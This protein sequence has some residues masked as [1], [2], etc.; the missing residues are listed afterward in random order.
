MPER[1]PVAFHA[2]QLRGL[3]DALQKLAGTLNP[4]ADDARATP[5]KCCRLVAGS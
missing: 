5:K 3:V 4:F 1:G 2:D